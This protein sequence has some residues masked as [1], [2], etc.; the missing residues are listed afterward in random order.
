MFVAREVSGPLVPREGGPRRPV[1][2]FNAHVSMDPSTASVEQV[3]VTPANVNDGRTGPDVCLRILAR[4]LPTA[5]IEARIRNAVRA[6]GGF[7]RIAATATWGRDE[8]ETLARL[9]AWNAPIRRSYSKYPPV[10][11]IRVTPP[12]MMG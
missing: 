7:L 2:G 11:P 4:R 1:H 8:Q 5:P 10:S 3:A 6:K 12:G 9:D